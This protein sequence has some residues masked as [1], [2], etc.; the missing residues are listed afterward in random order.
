MCRRD[1]QQGQAVQGQLHRLLATRLWRHVRHH[2]CGDCALSAADG[3]RVHLLCAVLLL[4]LPG[5]VQVEGLA[6]LGQQDGLTASPPAGTLAHLA[7]PSSYDVM[8]T[9][10][11]TPCGSV[12]SAGKCDTCICASAV[13][14]WDA[15][16]NLL[17]QGCSILAQ[18]ERGYLT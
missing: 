5:S 16:C 10:C 17:Q 15:S 18:A 14:V 8:M 13:R 2:P 11:A 4:P 7:L 12:G 3:L 1:P 9:V 6:A